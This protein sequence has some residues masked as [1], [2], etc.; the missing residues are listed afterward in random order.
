MAGPKL[1]VYV[2]ARGKCYLI[3]QLTITIAVDSNNCPYTSQLLKW[4]KE[5]IFIGRPLPLCGKA[6]NIALPSLENPIWSKKSSVETSL[7][8]SGPVIL[9]GA[10]ITAIAIA[11]HILPS[12]PFGTPNAHVAAGVINNRGCKESVQ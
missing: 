6:Q 11:I 5:E 4:G 12:L 7:V 8:C 10:I 2:V 9:I 3:F 1:F